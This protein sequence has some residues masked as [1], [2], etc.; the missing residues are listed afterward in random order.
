MKQEEMGGQAKARRGRL[1]DG[2]DRG[3]GGKERCGKGEGRKGKHGNEGM[4]RVQDR[5]GS[6]QQE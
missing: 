4:A 6:G 1:G 2:E 5:S 3:R